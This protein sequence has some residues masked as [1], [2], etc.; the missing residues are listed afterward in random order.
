MQ[1]GYVVLYVT[2]SDACLDFWINRVGMELRETTKVM[3]ESIH[4]VG[5]SDS[6]FAF[7]LVPLKLMENN[8]EKLDLATPSICFYVND[9]NDE[10]LR[11]KGSGITVSE[12]STRGDKQSF[13]FSDNE[14]RW[15][16]VMEVK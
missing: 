3:D 6:N 5:F 11:L 2:D 10:H 9:I 4:K 14:A 8:P 13:A 12:I 15:F 16:A 1:I 7:E